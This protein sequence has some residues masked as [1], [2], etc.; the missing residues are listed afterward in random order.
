MNNQKTSVISDNKPGLINHHYLLVSIWHFAASVE[1]ALNPRFRNTP[2]AIIENKDS[3][4]KIIDFNA[5]AAGLGIKKDLSLKKALQITPRLVIRPIQSNHLKGFANNFIKISK[6]WGEVISS[7]QHEILLRIPYSTPIERA[8]LF[9]KIQNICWQ[10]LECKIVAGFGSSPVLAKLANLTLRQPRFRYFDK[11]DKV[12]LQQVPIR[13]LPGLGKQNILKLKNR[14][15]HSVRD[16]INET[17]GNIYSLLGR[18]GLALHYKVIA[19]QPQPDLPE[20]PPVKP[21]LNFGLFKNNFSA[22]TA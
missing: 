3:E 8:I 1:E 21:R 9:L 13:F 6:K 16:F 22:S 15:I 18:T 11:A 5:I 10:E 20:K 7:N 4:L 2:L 19:W 14:G 12:N 17:S